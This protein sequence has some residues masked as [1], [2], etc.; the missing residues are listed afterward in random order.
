MNTTF[1]TAGLA[2]VIAAIVGGG[3]NAFSIE[4]P[5]LS[6]MKRQVLLGILGAA[7]LAAGFFVPA[8]ADE[9]KAV[10][11]PRSSF[12][13]AGRVLDSSDRPIPGASV[14]VGG[15][16]LGSTDQL[17]NFSIPVDQEDVSVSISG[18]SHRSAQFNVHAPQSGLVFHL[19]A[20]PNKEAKTVPVND[21][22]PSI[23]ETSSTNPKKT[24]TE[25]KSEDAKPI[26]PDPA[27]E[28]K[29][30]PTTPEVKT[31]AAP[32]TPQPSLKDVVQRAT[33]ELRENG[34]LTRARRVLSTVFGTNASTWD[35]QRV[36]N[37]LDSRISSASEQDLQ[38]VKQLLG[39]Q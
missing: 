28:H 38:M 6:S 39:I 2:C 32:V 33:R 31:N 23:P 21:R 17:G 10:E 3:L 18:P 7:L 14:V 13:I 5:L 9:S 24:E 26:Q 35:R 16:M 29:D 34:D 27:P 20:L 12:R 1:V 30:V 25:S 8:P 4:I 15:Q 37:T 22:K 11:P 36:F 19:D